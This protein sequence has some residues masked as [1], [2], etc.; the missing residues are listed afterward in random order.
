MKKALL[1]GINAYPTAPLRGCLNDVENWHN[2]LTGIGGYNPNNIRAVCDDRATT[3]GIKDRMAWLREGI[4]GPGDEVIFQYSGHGSQIR[5]R[6]PFDELADHKDEI[7]CPVDLDWKHNLI[8]DDYLGS[9]LKTFPA[10]TRIILILDCCHSGTGTRAL[11]PPPE[12][13][14]GPEGEK[15][16]PP[17]PQD[18]R[19]RFLEPPLDIQLRLKAMTGERSLNGARIGMGR[20]GWRSQFKKPS[21]FCRM[22]WQLWG[23]HRGRNP[24]VRKKSKPAAV[25]LPA[26]NHVLISGCQSDQTSADAFIGGKYNG[27]MSYFMA[28]EIRA[29]A[30]RPI[31]EIQNT[32]R[33]AIRGAGYSQISQLEGPD[34]LLN[35]PLFPKES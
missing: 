28:Q 7:L 25:K 16:K 21:M 35:K 4:T 9:W 23:R 12:E 20:Q 31:R 30:N 18:V 33:D 10:G 26:M 3:K 8:N 22:W 14:P 13:N 17:V 6:F 15:E 34:D 27:A 1:V 2:V 11:A 5:D 32:A 19:D 24:K 29:G